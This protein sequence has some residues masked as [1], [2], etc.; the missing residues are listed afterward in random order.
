M[1]PQL[2]VNKN[3]TAR[4]SML[5]WGTAGCGKTHL[6]NTAPGKRLFLNFDPDG[7][8][9]LP[10]S[11]D[12]LLLDYAHESDACVAQAFSANPYGLDGILKDHPDINT[13]VVDSVT[14]FTAKAVRWSTRQVKGATEINPGPAGYQYRNAHALQLCT[15]LL[16]VTA[17]Y[18]RNVIF[19]CHEDAL[20][21]DNGAVIAITIMLG[22]KL[23]TQ[24]PL[25]ISEVWHLKDNT[26]E[27]KVTV[28]QVGQ[29]KPM[30]TRMFDTTNGFDFVVS[31]IARPDKVR[32]DTL[33]T[34]WRDAK[35]DK[36]RM[37]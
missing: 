1:P 17:R 12:T 29:Y 25:H 26:T 10:N 37:P 4:V 11:D 27:R 35:Y 19:I 7:T 5:L 6:A 16:L 14:A 23:P 21:N 31:D 28:R 18:N 22:G 36:I 30:K 13:V 24:V 9:A 3:A 20:M 8:A 32:L 15:G 2:Q 34:R 33:F